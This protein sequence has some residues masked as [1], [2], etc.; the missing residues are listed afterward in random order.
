MKND[1]IYCI[2]AGQLMTKKENNPI[3]KQNRYLNYGLLALASTLKQNG[4][5]PIQIHGH[6]DLPSGTLD[7]CIC[8]GLMD[9][10]MP[11]LISIPSHYAVSWTKQFIMLAKQINS[12]I[13]VIIGGRWVIGERP[14][15]LKRLI[16]EADLII[17]GI[18]DSKICEIIEAYA[19]SPQ[20]TRSSMLKLKTQYPSL[21]YSLL[22]ERS[23]YQPSIEISRGCGMGCAFCME[24]DNTRQP[25]KDALFLS[26]ELK[27]NLLQ[28]NLNPMTPYF[29]ASHFVPN[30]KWINGL[31]MGMKKYGLNL[32]WRTEA[33]VDTFKLDCLKGLAQSGLKVLDLGLESASHKQLVKMNKSHNPSNYLS[34][35]SKLLRMAHEY[36]IK[37]KINILFSIGETDET[38]SE[39]DAWLEQHR[40][41]ITGISA[42][43]QI[44]FGWHETIAPHIRM[45]ESNGGSIS[46]SPCEGITHINLSEEMDYEQSIERAN[47]LSRKYMTA[48]DYFYLKSFS[49]FPRNY[50]YQMF[51]KDIFKQSCDY[52]FSTLNT[53]Q[54][55][56]MVNSPEIL[57]NSMSLPVD[58]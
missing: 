20:K 34:R 53:S 13:K 3:N 8:L 11:L 29:E 35:A 36:D 41:F 33:R 40:E 50:S 25:L 51:L 23:L 27:A 32:N 58:E 48:E 24:K 42:G 52:S 22:F 39:T 26:Q 56:V 17:P 15:L 46:H 2:S 45:L 5:N 38:L 55:A 18:A 9:F 10:T 28:D 12:K 30:E 31:L 4:W 7:N 37:I 57:Q 54:K 49:Y 47:Q 14:D 19:P 6:F 21:D 1:I 16:P 43:P 44:L